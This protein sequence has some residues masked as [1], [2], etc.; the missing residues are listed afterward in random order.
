[1]KK[2]KIKG[3]GVVVVDNEWAVVDEIWRE[4]DEEEEEKTL[5]V[6]NGEKENKE[7]IKWK[8]CCWW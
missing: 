3:K 8:M 4:K 1:M 7:Q 5:V 2:R 6:A